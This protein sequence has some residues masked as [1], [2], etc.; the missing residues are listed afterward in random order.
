M[1]DMHE[2]KELLREIRDLQRAH[3]ERYKEFTQVVLD[4]QQSG[5]DEANRDRE[6]Q[7][8]F[9]EEMRHT[10]QDSQQRVRALHSSRWVLVAIAVAFAILA[11][12]GLLMQLLFHVA[13]M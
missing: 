4:R 9:R 13:Q 10:I 5:A 3:F 1:D 8:R 7:R 12:G 11:F 2:I 6:E